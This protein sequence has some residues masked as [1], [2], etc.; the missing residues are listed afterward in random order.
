MNYS[1]FENDVSIY[2]SNIRAEDGLQK[3]SSWN[4]FCEGVLIPVGS[5][6]AVFLAMLGLML[7]CD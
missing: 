5:L 2:Q 7:I 4:S 6:F 3:R 1:K